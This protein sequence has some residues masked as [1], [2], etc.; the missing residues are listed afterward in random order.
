MAMGTVKNSM[1]EIVVYRGHRIIF[2]LFAFLLVGACSD[3]GLGGPLPER[4]DPHPAPPAL[5]RDVA[6][7]SDD[8]EH[9]HPFV[10]G[11]RTTMDGRVAVR[12]QGGPPGGERLRT[13][14]SFF[15]FA[16]EA[17]TAPV[18]A[19]PPGVVMMP[20]T[21]SVDVTFPP[22]LATNVQR[23]GHHAICDATE[24]FAREGERPNPYACGP[25]LENDC[26]DIT[27]VNS[28]AAAFNI[29]MYGTPATVV[30]AD[31]KTPAARIVDVTLGEPVQGQQIGLTLEFM[32]PSVT[33][34]GRLL[35]GRLGGVPR[36]WTHPQSGEVLFRPYDLVYSLLPDDAEPCDVTGWT[37]FHP[38]SHAPHDPRMKGRYGIANYR[39]R[40]TEGRPIPDGEDMGGTYPWVDREG[41]NVF[42]TGV[43]GRLS[44]QSEDQYPR[45]CVV[46][47][48]KNY[49]E[50]V[51]FD[52]GYMVAGAWT[53]GKLVHL[54]GMINSIDWAV[55]VTP[56]MHYEVDLYRDADGS[57]VP[58][59]VGSGRFVEAFRG[60]GPYP[61]GYTHNPNILDSVQHLPNFARYARTI[62]PRDVV[63]IMSTGVATDE[64]AFDDFMDP[65]ALI[66]SNMQASITQIYD[67]NGESTNMPHHWNGQVR[68]M[69]SVLLKQYVLQPGA[70]ADIHIQNAAT[71][72]KRPI[73]P[74][75]HVAAGT[76]R[77]EPVALGGIKGRGFWLSGEN[78]IVY[79]IPRQPEELEPE[80]WYVG[81]FI[82]AHADDGATR[83]LLTFPD[84][85]QL[86]L[87]NSDRV[88]YVRNERIEHEV[89]LPVADGFRHLGLRI[90]NGHRDITLLVDGM[91]FDRYEGR[92]PMFRVAEGNLIV[93][94]TGPDVLALRGPAAEMEAGARGWIDNFIVLARDVDPESACNQANGT[95]VRVDSAESWAGVAGLYPAWAH[96][97]IA[98]AAGDD[99]DARYVCYLDH[100]RDYGAHLANIPDG[101]TSVRQ[102]IHFPEGPVRTGAPRPD[103]TRNTFCLSCHHPEGRGGL[104]LEALAYNPDVLAE[105]DPRR[106]PHQP[107]RRVFGNIPANWIPPG[108]KE[109]GSPAE[110]MR[111]PAE[112]A[113]ID[114]WVLP[115]AE[116]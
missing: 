5:M 33:M 110:A 86:R 44:E 55:G 113:L 67:A 9:T 115:P 26:Y 95:L 61:P 2:V 85:T 103:S 48:C 90:G 8:A 24:P 106:Q 77:V 83:A 15:L 81:I 93:G 100:R 98:D 97:A 82:D 1:P 56:S 36:A 76:G 49:P 84:D 16:P 78:A 41:A 87:V 111:A 79:S 20:E 109:P 58:V 50:N 112:G 102:A 74:Y 60:E 29:S 17:L 13:M 99:S 18:L 53:H 39:F 108:P 101:L 73:P 31:P 27:I 94:R 32:E 66:V 21:S 6:L 11:H 52:R 23:M 96:A 91:E 105:N 65:A 47:G 51:D 116:E 30:V 63:W 107:P 71:T 22:A 34:D 88:Q 42:M 25:L 75:G 38:I 54:D 40:D 14:I 69:V 37:E 114:F 70:Q 4:Y 72:L 7:V 35:T 57:P 80:T 45:R 46:P 59:R 19:G 62:T 10:P 89:E 12:V 68:D 92:R 43:H 64:I 28:V 3:G 104:T